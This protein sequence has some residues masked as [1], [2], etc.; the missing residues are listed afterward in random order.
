[1]KSRYTL[2]QH[3]VYKALI[4]PVL[5]FG[6]PIEL[7]VVLSSVLVWLGMLTTRLTWIMIPI[8]IFC[9]GLLTKK[10]PFFFHI[11]YLKWKTRQYKTN[12]AIGC[13]ALFA[14]RYTTKYPLGVKEL[15]GNKWD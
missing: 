3:K 9:L 8:V 6:V 5:Y 4:R 11:L 2:T 12:K 10:D 1:M 13:I 15:R 7:L 14:R